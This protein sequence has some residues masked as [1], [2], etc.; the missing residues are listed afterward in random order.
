M[1]ATAALVCAAI[2]LASQMPPDRLDAYDAAVRVYVS[3]GDLAEPVK[4]LRAFTSEDFDAAAER[5]IAGKDRALSQAAAV[6]QLEIAVGVVAV[7]PTMASE[8]LALGRLL[9]D[10]LV[11]EPGSAID[12]L[13][14]LRATWYGV[15]GS[16]FLSIN[17]TA[18]ANVWIKRALDLRPDSPG[19]RALE[20]AAHELDAAYANPD[21]YASGNQKTRV[22]I[23]RHRRLALAEGAFRKALRDDPSFIYAELRLGRVLFLRGNIAEAQTVLE[24]AAARA[25]L[26][27]DRYLASLFLG[28][29]HQQRGDLPAAR[30]AL[31]RAHAAVPQSQTAVVAL[32]HG[33]LMTGRA[34]SARTLVRSLVDAAAVDDRVW[35]AYKNGGVDARGLI[36]LRAR[37]RR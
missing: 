8:H 4:R 28:A 5:I 33:D 13:A 24:R 32:A 2:S 16:V 6:F 21:F 18:S 11:P 3:G 27:S 36:S 25:E 20:G 17:D 15:A 29:L 37:V 1:L 12:D 34:D 7:A 30:A 35:S 26:T 31:E 10:Q 14:A 23:E 9:L 19:A 22:T